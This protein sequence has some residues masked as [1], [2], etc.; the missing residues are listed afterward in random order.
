MF[1]LKGNGVSFSNVSR[2]QVRFDVNQDGLLDRV[3][4]IKGKDDAVLA[5]DRNGNGKVDGPSE[6]SFL[7]DLLGARSDMEG[8]LGLDSDRDGFLTAGDATFGDFMLWQDRNGNGLSERGE[9]ISLSDAGI[10]SIGLEILD[11]AALDGGREASQILGRSTVIF[12]DGREIDAY[13]VALDTRI[14]K[15]PGCGCGGSSEA[16][17]MV[18]IFSLL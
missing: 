1:D 18:D 9:L 10:T 6:I 15:T 7:A 12:A 16:P 8:L 11:R 4:W 3:G 14:A 13:D 17:F 5:L 2:S